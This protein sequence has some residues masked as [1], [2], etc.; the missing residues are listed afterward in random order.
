MLSPEWHE[1]AMFGTTHWLP[2]CLFTTKLGPTH[3][4]NPKLR[5]NSFL[6]LILESRSLAG[7]VLY[8]SAFEIY[9]CD[10][11]TPQ[12]VALV[13]SFGSQC[14]ISR[15]QMSSIFANSNFAVAGLSQSPP[16]G[17]WLLI[18]FPWRHLH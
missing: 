5:A 7:Q 9:V 1:L 14:D 8:V 4:Q 12:E 11:S 17:E 13:L 16:A 18:S 15:F 6:P 3:L 2:G 10:V